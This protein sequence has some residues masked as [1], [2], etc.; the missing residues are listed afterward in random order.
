LAFNWRCDVFGNVL[1]FLTNVIDIE[2]ARTA[3]RFRW[4]VGVNQ[5][6]PVANLPVSDWLVDRSETGALVGA[7]LFAKPNAAW[8]SHREQ[9]RPFGEPESQA[10]V[11]GRSLCALSPV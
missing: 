4:G 5:S 11:L 9:V 6:Y 1:A 2:R 3:F 8:R 7:N 10:S